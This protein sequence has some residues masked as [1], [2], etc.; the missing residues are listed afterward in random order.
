MSERGSGDAGVK[1]ADF[2]TAMVRPRGASKTPR[3]K[4]SRIG[5]VLA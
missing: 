3:I 1:D 4:R 2:V 5:M